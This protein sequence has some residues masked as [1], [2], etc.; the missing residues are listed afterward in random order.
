MYSGALAVKSDSG[1]VLSLLDGGM[2]T[3]ISRRDIVNSSPGPDLPA[4]FSRYKARVEQELS[5][6]VPSP[7]DAHLYTLLRYH[8]G[9]ASRNG[10]PADVPISQGKAMRPTLCLFACEALEGDLS[11]AVPVAAALELIHNFSLIHDDIQDGDLERRHRPT[12]WHLWGVR[13]ALVAGNAM[14][15]LADQ[16]L[17]RISQLDVSP[18]TTLKISQLL[19]GSC[20]EMIQG[21]CLDLEFEAS[22]GVTSHDYLQMIACKTGALIRSGLEMGALL[23]IDDPI[24]AQA[25]SHFGSY[26]GQ[27]FQIRDDFLGIWGDEATTGKAA[28][29]DIR[30]R[31]K[32][33][34]VVFALER[35]TGRAREDLLQTYSQE[36][37]DEDDVARVLAVLDEVGAPEYSQQLTEE[38]AEQAIQALQEVPLPSWARTE[39]EELVDFLARRRF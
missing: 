25:F 21:Q 8:L 4:M 38:S 16:V 15:S 27:V 39:V 31:K 14:Q 13:R 5:L 37:L 29:N 1:G 9:W 28:G 35:S 32:S 18:E 10:E 34:P 33:F 3:G 22:T 36:S 7:Q 2:G 12:V 26:L 11:Q 19:T 6:A 30:R 20:L 23:A 17:L 24:P